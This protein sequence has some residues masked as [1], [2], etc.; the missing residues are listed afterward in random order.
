MVPLQPE[1]CFLIGPR[2]SG[3]STIGR[4]LAAA[5]GWAF[6]DTDALVVAQAGQ[7]IAQLVAMHGWPYFRNF[8]CKALRSANTA[9]TVVATGGGIILDPANSDF[10]R[11]HGSVFYLRT[12]AAVL[13]ARLGAQPEHEQ[14]PPLSVRSMEDEV[15]EVLREREP[16]YGAAAHYILDA[17]QNPENVVREAC[18]FLL[19]AES[20]YERQTPSAR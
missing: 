17:A 13:A 3:K 20:L 1:C 15:A 6:V 18:A 5:L 16:L 7:S 9:R 11:A 4:K 14:R 19:A 2:G 12:D 8:E 10:M